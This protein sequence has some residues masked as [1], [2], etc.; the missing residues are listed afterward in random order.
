MIDPRLRTLRAVREAGTVTA[1]AAVLHIT[2]STVSQHLKQLSRL[3]GAE[4]VEPVG[5]NV[6]LTEAAEIVLSHTEAL[7]AE[8]ERTL[9][10]LAALRED[11]GARLRIS[12]VASA[13]VSLICPAVD[14]L[15]D[16]SPRVT[17]EIGEN[18]A[19]DRFRM[20]ADAETD[21]VVTVT[22]SHPLAAAEEP[23]GE[24]HD[25][26]VDPLD[27]LVG[28]DYPLARAMSVGL[29]ELAEETWIGAGDIRDQQ[30][31]FAELCAQAGFRPRVRH[32]ALD[33]SAV[34][35]LVGGGHGIALFPR[36]V[37]LPAGAAVSR[38]P[39]TWPDSPAVPHRLLRAYVRRG[40]A[41]HP[42]IAAGL[43]ALQEQGRILTG[44]M[45]D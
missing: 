5:R 32:D 37:A 24:A 8:W 1:A 25:L 10:D 11:E 39:V 6:R 18:A 33:W 17:V 4:L 30:V 35:A 27:V 12:G 14:R 2:P 42:V 15:R 16:Q 40:S 19:R 41:D 20:L 45:T 3:V 7:D 21:I 28:A 34:A 36:T 26:L 13:I 38:V 29:A 43:A 9:S 23:I 44:A 31:V 22:G